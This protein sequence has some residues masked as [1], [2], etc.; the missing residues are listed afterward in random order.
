M[1][2][3]GAVIG[4]LLALTILVAR[5]GTPLQ[6]L[7][8]VALIPGLLSASLAAIAVRDVPH[9]KDATAKPPSLFLH[10]P[11]P[12]WHLILAATLFSLGNSSDSFLILRSKQ[13]G[14]TLPRVILAYCLYN[15]VYAAAALPLGR[16][17]DRIGRKPVIVA[18][19]VVYAVVYLGFSMA[20]SITAPWVLLA[21]YG[22]YQA[23]TEGVTKAMIADV[24]PREQ[25][26]GAIGLFYT[27]T[28]VGQLAASLA[29]GALWDVRLFHGSVMLSFLLGSICATAAIPLMAT[30]RIARTD[31]H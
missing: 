1:D 18:G 12:L 4:P 21:V 6:W 11:W 24:A 30:V 17:S 26:A 22:L 8:L 5:P 7:F 29:A 23:L 13:I 15:A 10:Y 20:K 27:L 16:V 9:E 2:T 3:A 31:D 19:F 28:G 25:R 14:L